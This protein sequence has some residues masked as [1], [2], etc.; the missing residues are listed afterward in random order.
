MIALY[1]KIFFIFFC[2]FIVTIVRMWQG[3]D[4]STEH[5]KCKYCKLPNVFSVLISLNVPS[6]GYEGAMVHCFQWFTFANR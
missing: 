3:G 6:F 5:P 1:L 2:Y 4:M